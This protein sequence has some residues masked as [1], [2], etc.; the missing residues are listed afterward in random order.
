VP[1]KTIL[2]MRVAVASVLGMGSE[3]DLPTHWD[4][5]IENGI[6][7]GKERIRRVIGGKGYTEAQIANWDGLAYWHR[8]ASLFCAFS[9]ANLKDDRALQQLNNFREQLVQLDKMESFQVAG[10]NIDPAGGSNVG[11]GFDDTTNDRFRMDMTL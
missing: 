4:D 11:F 10:E 7:G 6:D 5:L 1:Y 2:Q 8:I 3:S 9:D